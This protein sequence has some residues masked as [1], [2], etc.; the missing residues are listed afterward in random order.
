[1]A[2]KGLTTRCS[3][4]VMAFGVIG[5]YGCDPVPAT[6]VIIEVDTD[7]DVPEELNAL[8]IEVLDPTYDTRDVTRDIPNVEHLPATLG[9]VHYEGEL[10]PFVVTAIGRRGGMARVDRTASF[11]FVPERTLVLPLRLLYDC[12]Y[13]DCPQ[14]E[15]CTENGCA[16][17][18]IDSSTLEPWTGD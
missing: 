7:L 13:Q 14:G 16:S 17:I 6:E 11:F 3:F 10:G 5:L 9:L 12:L 18:D 15:T 8:T 4:L 2:L 1:M